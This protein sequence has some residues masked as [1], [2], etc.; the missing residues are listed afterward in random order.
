M[1]VPNQGPKL[2]SQILVPNRGPKSGSQIG[3]PNRGPKSWSQIG[4]SNGCP[5]SGSQIGG[6][7]LLNCILFF[8][9]NK[10]FSI[11]SNCSTNCGYDHVVL[12]LALIKLDYNLTSMSWPSS[13]GLRGRRRIY[14]TILKRAWSAHYKMVW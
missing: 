5:K 7:P 12:L 13:S 1:G 3:V 14:L 9:K 10:L 8:P 2:G 11:M 6:S 4:V